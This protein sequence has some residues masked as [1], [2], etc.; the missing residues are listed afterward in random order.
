MDLSKRF[1]KLFSGNDRAHGTFNVQ[2][3]RATDGKKTGQARVLREP[4]TTDLWERH[5]AG[6]SGLG[7][8]PIKDNNC[9][10]WGAI[11]I[12][13]YNLDHSNLI[14]QVEKHNLPGV[15]CRSK[16]GGA[17]L[18][19]FFT[20]ELA[21]ADLQPKLMS[22]A[23]LLG[24]AGSEVFPKQQQI[25]VDRGDTGNFLNMPY[26]GGKMTTRY[27][28]NDKGEGLSPEEFL[29]FAEGRLL[30]PDE[31][32]DRETTPKK[33]E[34]ILPKGPPCLQHLAAMG[35]GEGSRNNALFNLAIYARLSNP[36]HWQAKTA[37]YNKTFMVPPLE[38]REVDLIV[39]Q[40]EKKE[41]FYKCDD[42]PIASHCNKEVCISR[43]FG[44]G[45][46]ATAADL[47]SL[48][49]IDGDPPV[50]ILDV[51][52]RRVELG[53]DSLVSQINFQRDC[54]NQ[55]NIFPKK[56]SDKAWNARIQAMLAHLTI[57]EVPPEATTKGEFEDLLFAFCC[58]RARGADREEILQGIAVWAE[59]RVYFQ[60]RDLKKHLTT[61]QFT[62]YSA[63]RIGMR[64]K[65]LGGDRMF[66]N[67]K[68]KGV[69]VWAIKQS[70][71]HG[72]DNIVLEVPKMVSP[73]ADDGVM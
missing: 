33:A 42:Q 27:G 70:F 47:G 39:K 21:A 7:I 71:F 34:E 64:L 51:D 29:E 2:N 36:D 18:Y 63:V 19:F 68:G 43:K 48:T 61:N 4:P 12:D 16:S 72:S 40:V 60:V 10:H 11:D 15:V 67:V 26:F 5:L 57:V 44:V 59:G 1:F 58:D 69:H 54:L 8:I 49:K 9:C 62:H 22:I 53:T 52:G 14:K 17:H 25:L 41:Y 66:W 56:M 65:E 28:H 31:F 24:Y 37:E 6:E 13:T 20:Q 32:L 55:I 45:P 38:D 46:G 73:Q 23:A 35:F 3:N 30:S 50:W